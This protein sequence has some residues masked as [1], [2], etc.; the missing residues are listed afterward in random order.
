MASAKMR[1]FSSETAPAQV[2]LFF[3]FSAG[4]PSTVNHQGPNDSIAL[5]HGGIRGIA[6]RSETPTFRL[7]EVAEMRSVRLFT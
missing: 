6:A 5:D 4:V 7:P 2:L 3:T 1:T